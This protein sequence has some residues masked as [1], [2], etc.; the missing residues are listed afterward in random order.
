MVE[1]S[2]EGKVVEGAVMAV[3]SK[4]AGIEVSVE[5]QRDNVGAYPL[6]AEPARSQGLGGDALVI[7]SRHASFAEQS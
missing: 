3:A 4:D 7:L 2:E 1:V 6:P 5:S